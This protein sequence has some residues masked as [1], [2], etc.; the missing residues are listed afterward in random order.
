MFAQTATLLTRVGQKPP[1]AAVPAVHWIG[2]D[3]CAHELRYVHA[4]TLVQAN[5][6][7]RAI[8][9]PWRLTA[10]GAE[11]LASS[12]LSF[13]ELTTLRLAEHRRQFEGYNVQLVRLTPRLRL[14]RPALRFMS[15]P[16]SVA[17]GATE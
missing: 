14:T 2:W 5:V 3:N 6:H 4:I 12:T 7:A 15:V 11:A 1:G 9:T 8:K 17:A 13:R 16:R 10:G